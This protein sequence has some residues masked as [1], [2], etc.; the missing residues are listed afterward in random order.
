MFFFVDKCFRVTHPSYDF[1]QRRMEKLKVEAKSSK[2]KVEAKSPKLKAINFFQ[3][4]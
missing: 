4:E 1:I 3:K 2:L